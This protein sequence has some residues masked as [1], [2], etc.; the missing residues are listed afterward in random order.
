MLRSI[1]QR[2]G[3]GAR[4][5]PPGSI[6]RLVPALLVAWLV[7]SAASFAADDRAGVEFFESKIRP[8][9]VEKCHQCHSASAA[10]PKGGLRL[11]TRTGIRKGGNS[12]PA[13]VPGDLEASILFQAIT[14]SDGVDPMPPKDKLSPAVIADFRQWIQS[15]A[16]DPRGDP[17]A[18]AQASGSPGQVPAPAQSGDWWS[19]RPLQ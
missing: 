15:G 8:V 7:W 1:G 12:G 3:K 16:S 13:V 18:G 5:L 6:Y 4:S 10:K 2:I 19:L 14:G 17:N 9:L 11:D